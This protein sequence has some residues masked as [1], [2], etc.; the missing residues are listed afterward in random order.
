MIDGANVCSRRQVTFSK[1]RP[2]ACFHRVS[3]IFALVAGIKHSTSIARKNQPKDRLLV[4]LS[5][6]N[7]TEGTHPTMDYPAAA[8][9]YVSPKPEPTHQALDV[10][11]PH[12]PA[13]AERSRTP[14]SNPP[15]AAERARA[16]APN[17]PPSPEQLFEDLV[18]GP[19]NWSALNW[20]VNYDRNLLYALEEVIKSKG[21]ES[22]RPRLEQLRSSFDADAIWS[23]NQPLLSLVHFVL[24]GE[25]DVHK[26]M[27][28]VKDMKGIICAR[29]KLGA[30]KKAELLE[31]R[32]HPVPP[33]GGGANLGLG[34]I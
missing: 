17:P 15:A 18:A 11:G 25:N 3:N 9:P 30:P 2:S 24:T 1:P 22:I 27:I 26:K 8:T 4:N 28:R 33:E 31:G 14:A 21:V 16:P 10:S 6:Q 23:L 32:V 7:R 12:T 29:L 20:T 19:P 34:K 13:A 5:I